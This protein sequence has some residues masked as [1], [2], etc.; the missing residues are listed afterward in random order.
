VGIAGG[1]KD[2]TLLIEEIPAHDH[3]QVG[4]VYDNARKSGSNSQQ[5]YQ[6]GGTLKTGKTGGQPDGSTKSFSLLNPY[7]IVMFIEYIGN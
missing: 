5:V 4:A 7:R 1:A 3:D 2:K 6:P